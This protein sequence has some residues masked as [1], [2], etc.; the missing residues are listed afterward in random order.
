MKSEGFKSRFPI[1]GHERK[2]EPRLQLRFSFASN[3]LQIRSL[4][5]PLKGREIVLQ[6][7]EQSSGGK[8]K[9]NPADGIT[10]V[11]RLSIAV[12][13][14]LKNMLLLG[15]DGKHLFN[16]EI[17]SR[18]HFTSPVRTAYHRIG[19]NP[20]YCCGLIAKALSG[21]HNSMFINKI[22]NY[23]APTALFEMNGNV[24]WVSPT[25]IL[26]RL[27]KAWVENIHSMWW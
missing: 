14:R 3:S 13:F 9:G 10:V 18:K 19:C 8:V 20:I 6:T 5:C 4:G 25:P 2:C 21:R 12:R 24:T 22:W 23:T 1:K 7:I 26:F 17:N 11:M 15:I 27:Y 16:V